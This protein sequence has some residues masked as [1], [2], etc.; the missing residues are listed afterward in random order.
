MRSCSLRSRA[1]LPGRVSASPN[2]RRERKRTL[3]FESF[4]YRNQQ[5]YPTKGGVYLLVPER[6]FEPPRLAALAPKASVSAISPPRQ[7]VFSNLNIPYFNLK[8]HPS[9]TL[10]S[11]YFNQVF[12]LL[13][14]SRTNSA[15]LHNL[16]LRFKGALFLPIIYNPLGVS[17]ANPGQ[18]IELS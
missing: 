3:G 9:N 14:H 13:I 2:L 12:D 4:S 10:L 11:L 16:F 15:D 17:S 8:V 18:G 5:I 7:R 1:P 6:G